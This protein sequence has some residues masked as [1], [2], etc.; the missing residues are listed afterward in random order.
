ML[1]EDKGKETV[2][3]PTISSL[4][5]SSRKE[6]KDMNKQRF[7]RSYDVNVLHTH[8]WWRISRHLKD[9][10]DAFSQCFYRRFENEILFKD[11]VL[12]IDILRG[13]RKENTNDIGT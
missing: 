4:R 5:F 11:I 2:F 3:P 7:A 8:T 13:N 1:S 10:R 9:R 12:R 6:R